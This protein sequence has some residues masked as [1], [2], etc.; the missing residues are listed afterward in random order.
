MRRSTR[1]W[2]CSRARCTRCAPTA[3]QG[4]SR[5]V[6][7][8]AERHGINVT[9]GAWIDDHRD[10]NEQELQTAIELAATH[11]NVV[12][13]IVGNEVVLRGDLPIGELDAATSIGRAM[14]SG[15]RSAPPSPGTCGW[16]T[17][18][19]R[20]TSTSS[21]CTCCPTGR[22]C[23]SRPRSTTRSRS[24]GACRR[25]FR[26][27]RSWSPRS[28]GRAAAARASPRSPRMPTRRCSCA[29]SSPRAQKEQ[30]IYYVMEAFDQPWK[31]YQEGAVG[32]YWGVYDVNRQPKFAFTAPIVRVPEWHI[33]AA[34]SVA[35]G[36]AAARPP[37]SQQRTRCATAAAAS[38]R[39]WCTPPPPSRCG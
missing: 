23:R 21:A 35:R 3:S 38:S 6:P 37:L 13:V 7:E 16:R 29:A 20:S 18:S 34:M 2:S 33:L 15:S 4:R 10:L 1:T 26:T 31:A 30:I 36:A 39:S 11:L 12:R 9:L 14:P 5:D 22:A 32:S 25:P 24:S 27:S 19:S 17:R 28:A 8:L